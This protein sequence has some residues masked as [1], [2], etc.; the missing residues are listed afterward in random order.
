MRFL[1]GIADMSVSTVLW[2]LVK[3]PIT[4]ESRIARG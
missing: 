1:H 2:V 4:A 3:C